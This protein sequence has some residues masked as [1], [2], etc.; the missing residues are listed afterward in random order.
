MFH[1]VE[2]NPYLFMVFWITVR[3]LVKVVCFVFFTDGT[4]ST[5]NLTTGFTIKFMWVVVFRA[6]S[7]FGYSQ[8]LYNYLE[9]VV[10]S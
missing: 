7:L 5:D 8:L 2:A 4:D 6:S 1:H 9:Q 10:D 3:Y